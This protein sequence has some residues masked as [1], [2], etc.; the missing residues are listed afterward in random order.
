[1]KGMI[2]IA[3]RCR[4]FAAT[5]RGGPHSPEARMLPPLAANGLKSRDYGNR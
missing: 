5:P 1:M 2:D 3:C 4:R